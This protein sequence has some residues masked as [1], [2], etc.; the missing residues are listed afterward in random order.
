MD[1]KKQIPT[2]PYHRYIE[3]SREEK[4]IYKAEPEMEV[5]QCQN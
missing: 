4:S 2:A 5:Q 3:W 1:N